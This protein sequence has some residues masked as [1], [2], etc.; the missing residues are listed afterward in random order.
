M[1]K[2]SMGLALAALLVAVVGCASSPSRPTAAGLAKQATK[3]DLARSAGSVQMVEAG[4]VLRLGYLD[5]FDSA[6]AL[7]GLQ[8]D[9]YRDDLAGVNLQATGYTSDLQEVFGL[10][11]G[12]LDAAYLDPVAALSA[13]QASAPGSLHIAAGATAE[14]SALVA[15]PGITHPSQ[16]RGTRVEAPYDSSQTAAFAAWISANHLTGRL[17]LLGSPVTATGILQQFKAGTVAAAWEPEPLAQQLIAAGGHALADTPA[18]T[19]A[20]VLVITER[21]ATANPTAVRDLLAAQTAA[22]AKFATHP[23]TAWT[24][25]ATTLSVSTSISIPDSVLTTATRRLTCATTINRNSIQALA[26]LAAAAHIT[27][28]SSSLS[29]LY[30]VTIT[31]P[32]P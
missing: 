23:V 13:W 7:L 2:I 1:K 15:Q 6:P 20:A 3:S 12:Q 10:E 19:S 5:D 28:P 29:S 24:A 31:P 11:H 30:D 4:Q 22:C 27:Q 32:A 17:S 16:L 25:A 8:T 18:D 9:L 14:A 26:R 21:Y